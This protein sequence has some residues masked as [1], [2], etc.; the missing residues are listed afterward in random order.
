MNEDHYN[1]DDE[2]CSCPDCWNA[3]VEYRDHIEPEYPEI[4]ASN[5]ENYDS[6]DDSWSDGDSLASAGWGMD[7]DYGNFGGDW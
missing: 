2:P 3:E 7:E 5:E 1:I 4:D 6:E